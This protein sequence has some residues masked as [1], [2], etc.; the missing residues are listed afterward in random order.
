MDDNKENTQKNQ[1][2]ETVVVED[3]PK[4]IPTA[5]DSLPEQNL[6]PEEVA[7]DVSSPEAPMS[8]GSNLPPEVPPVFEENKNQ[9]LLIVGAVIVFLIVFIFIFK[10]IFS[11]K[12]TPQPVTLNYW[13]LWEEKEVFEPLILDYQKKYPYVKINYQKME[14]QNYREKLLVRSRNNQGPD[15]FRFHNTWLPE[16]KEIASPIP[17]SIMSN[18]EFEKTFYKIHQKDL[19]VGDKYYGLPLEIDGLVL[20]YNVNLLKKAGIDKPPETWDELSNLIP[21]LTVKDTNGNIITAGVALGLTVNVEHFSDILA[22]MI[23]QNGSDIKKLDSE[24]AAGALESY[25]KFAEPPNNFWDENMPNSLTAFIQEKVAMIFVPSWQILAIKSANPEIEIK[26]IPVPSLP[27]APPVSIANYWVEGVSKMSQNQIEAW[28]FLRFL[29]EKD[30]LT[31]MYELS[32]RTRL[33]GEP[34]SRVDLAPLLV[35]NS[36]L[37]AVIKQ[38]DYFVSVP[39]ISRTFDNG[40]NDEIVKYL[41]NAVN[42]TIEGVSYNEALMTAKKGVDQV[43]EKY[44]L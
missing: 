35:Q 20:V 42:A 21:K 18:T 6:V 15:I 7:P 28:R 2:L 12:K 36:Y 13:G 37:G 43:F 10:L 29:I 14:S 25:R 3:Q 23:Y 19:K 39:A 33:F 1:P 17:A 11:G 16:I 44:K 31:K 30:S 5:T 26:A 27:G 4:E 32:S 41:E 9:P 8:S 40:L 34:Y 24:E 22:L 38:A